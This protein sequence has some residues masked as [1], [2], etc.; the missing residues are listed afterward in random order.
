[1]IWYI[2]NRLQFVPGADPTDLLGEAFL[3]YVTPQLDGLDR[4]AIISI[5][6]YLQD[7]IFNGQNVIGSLQRRIRSLYPHI[8][9]D[10]WKK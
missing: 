7:K 10:D 6:S 5:H 2:G 1:M 3:L 4:A 8:G 9:S